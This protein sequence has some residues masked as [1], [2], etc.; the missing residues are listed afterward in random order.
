MEARVAELEA[1]L[2][3]SDFYADPDA[4]QR[5]DALF[6]ELETTRKELDQAFAE[7]TRAAEAMDQR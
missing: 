7:W 6:Q 2:A 1:R 3:D 4:A 5:A